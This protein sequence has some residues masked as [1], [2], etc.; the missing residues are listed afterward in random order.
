MSHVENALPAAETRLVQDAEGK[1]KNGGDLLVRSSQEGRK[2]IYSSLAAN[3]A[4]WME[5]CLCISVP[6]PY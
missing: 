2:E 6:A 1:I 5:N 3:K 4:E